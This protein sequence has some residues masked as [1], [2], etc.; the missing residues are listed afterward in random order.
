MRVNDKISDAIRKRLEV[1]RV[2]YP[3]V[4]VEENESGIPIITHSLHFTSLLH[5]FPVQQME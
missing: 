2:V 4:L 1:E 5:R 3:L